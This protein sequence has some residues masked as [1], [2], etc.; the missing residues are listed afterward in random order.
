MWRIC[1]DP[2]LV[3]RFYW[4]YLLSFLEYCSPVWGSAAESH[5][6]LLDSVIRGANFLSCG[7]CC[8][9]SRQR[10]VALTIFDTWK[11]YLLQ[12][13]SLSFF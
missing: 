5:M 10:D 2:G 13:I 6:K 3:V 7:I 9:L 11:H 4:L 8:N 12:E 1:A